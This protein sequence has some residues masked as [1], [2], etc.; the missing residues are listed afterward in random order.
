MAYNT[1]S[2]TIHTSRRPSDHMMQLYLD[3]KETLAGAGVPNVEWYLF[4]DHHFVAKGVGSGHAEYCALTHE[5]EPSIHT[6][7]RYGSSG[8]WAEGLQFKF[9]KQ[10]PYQLHAE[11]T[12]LGLPI[13]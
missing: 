1:F 7:L 6:Y 10:A 8:G 9:I 12:L 4:V 2:L 5:G 11:A 13:T 3:F